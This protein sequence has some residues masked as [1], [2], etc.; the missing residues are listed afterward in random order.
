MAAVF[1]CLIGGAMMQFH[2]NQGSLPQIHERHTHYSHSVFLH[3]LSWNQC[4]FRA[5]FE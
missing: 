2:V 1:L 5:T 3:V 4:R